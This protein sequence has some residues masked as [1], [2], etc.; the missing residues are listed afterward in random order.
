MCACVNMYKCVKGRDNRMC[1]YVCVP[2]LGELIEFRYILSARRV[3]KKL[4]A[5]PL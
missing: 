3:L 5:D 4:Y 1:A 2:Y